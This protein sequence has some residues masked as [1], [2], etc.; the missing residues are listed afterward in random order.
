MFASLR[1]STYMI[2]FL[3]QQK[4]INLWGDSRHP[5]KLTFFKDAPGP[6]VRFL[7][8]LHILED[9]ELKKHLFAVHLGNLL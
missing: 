3:S 7:F 6:T 1:P 8:F 2:Q 9:L 4:H 5:H